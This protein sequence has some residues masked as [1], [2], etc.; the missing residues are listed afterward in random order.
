[1]ITLATGMIEG[2]VVEIWLSEFSK[3]LDGIETTDGGRIKRD[4]FAVNH[5]FIR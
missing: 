1:M 2:D 4:D 5:S 3:S